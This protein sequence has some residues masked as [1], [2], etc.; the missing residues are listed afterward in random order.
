MTIYF[1]DYMYILLLYIV[2][3]CVIHV[4]IIYAL[5]STLL[6][7]NAFIAKPLN[8]KS[9]GSLLLKFELSALQKQASIRI[10]S[11]YTN[12]NSGN[13]TASNSRNCPVEA[14][15]FGLSGDETLK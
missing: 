14:L 12:N 11:S 1:T 9:L 3:Y 7:M 5:Y 10:E 6:G 8:L 2:F 15:D 13:N 4:L